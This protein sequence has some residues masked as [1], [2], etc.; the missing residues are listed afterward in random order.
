MPIHLPEEDLWHIVANSKMALDTLRDERIF[1][2]GGTGFF[3]VWLLN[4]LLFANQKINLNVEIGVLTRNKK[5]FIE[6]N[7]HIEKE[8]K[9]R[10][11]DGDVRNFDF[12]EMHFSHLIHA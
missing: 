5:R 2:T 11:F 9:I 8:K 10:F 12:P 7:P 4:T 6:K 3:G 1:I